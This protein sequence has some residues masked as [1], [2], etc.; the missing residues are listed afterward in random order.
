MNRNVKTNPI[1]DWNNQIVLFTSS[2]SCLAV[3]K[4]VKASDLVACRQNEVTYLSDQ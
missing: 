4:T 1:L 2:F 3:I